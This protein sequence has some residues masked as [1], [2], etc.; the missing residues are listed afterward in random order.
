[1][2]RAPAGGYHAG[3][4]T[5]AVLVDDPRA[6][7]EYDLQR[8]LASWSGGLLAMIEPAGTAAGED[9]AAAPAF[10]PSDSPTTRALKAARVRYRLRVRGKEAGEFDVGAGPAT[11][12]G[13]G[14]PAPVVV[15]FVTPATFPLMLQLAHHEPTRSMLRVGVTGVRM[16][17][18]YNL[19]RKLIVD[20]GI[21][22]HEHTRVLEKVLCA[23]LELMLA[24][25][26]ERQRSV[27][28]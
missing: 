5:P 15:C 7:D 18:N 14:Q 17:G 2:I 26:A 11:L 27:P 23:R 28:G 1:L 20:G 10:G 12:Q 9:G 21:A 3:V 22:Y 6:N 24:A 8:A 19:A 4:K 25:H 13:F 16:D